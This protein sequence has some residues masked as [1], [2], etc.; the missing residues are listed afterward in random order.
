M[1]IS[2]ESSRH[3]AF[4]QSIFVGPLSDDSESHPCSEQQAAL[5]AQLFSCQ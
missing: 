3:T 5:L 2:E 4:V 1:D